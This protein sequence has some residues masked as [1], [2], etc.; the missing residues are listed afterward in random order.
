REQGEKIRFRIADPSIWHPRPDTRRKESHGITIHEDFTREGVH[1][2]KADNDRLHG[3]MQV[4]KR[5]KLYEDVYQETGEILAEQLMAW[6]FNDCKGFWRTFHQLRED[7]RNP[8]DVDTDQEDHIY[9]E[10]RY[11]C[12]ARPIR[13]KKVER[14]PTGSFQAE[15]NRLI[16]AK[17]YA[18]QHGVSVTV[19]YSRIR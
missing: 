18:R 9:D 7:P 8:E 1:F 12:M 4:H 14:I 17:R 16:R 15:R 19:A 6:F 2:L 3:K 13:P 11:M 5:L 10:F